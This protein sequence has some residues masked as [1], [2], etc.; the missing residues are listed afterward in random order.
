MDEK[1]EIRAT[2]RQR[3]KRERMGGNNDS[4]ELPRS[5]E[6]GRSEWSIKEKS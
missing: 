1:E 3:R 5:G 6:G 2:V 4:G